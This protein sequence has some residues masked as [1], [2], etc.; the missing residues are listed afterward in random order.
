M[1]SRW[2][3]A[4]A[5]RSLVAGIA[6]LSVSPSASAQWPQWRGPGGQ[7]ISTEQNLPTEWSVAEAGKP[8]VNIKW[9]T[10][11]PGRGH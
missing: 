10:E 6:L 8:A 11:I 7:G 2:L 9:E 5:G 1:T 3:P 4:S